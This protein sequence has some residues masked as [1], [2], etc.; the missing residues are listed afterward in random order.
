MRSGGRDSIEG[1]D[2]RQA[3]RSLLIR[4]KFRK[5]RRFLNQDAREP[6]PLL[7]AD[8]INI[9]YRGKQIFL[10]RGFGDDVSIVHGFHLQKLLPYH[11]LINPADCI[12]SKEFG[13]QSAGVRRILFISITENCFQHFFFFTNENRPKGVAKERAGKKNP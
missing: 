4:G 11:L 1:E 9:D 12:L 6:H 7:S 2:P 8:R 13:E 3:V 10:F 5:C